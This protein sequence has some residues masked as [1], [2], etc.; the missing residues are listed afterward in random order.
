MGKLRHSAM[1]QVRLALEADPTL[2]IRYPNATYMFE[3]EGGQGQIIFPYLYHTGSA[4]HVTPENYLYKKV[5]TDRFGNNKAALVH[6]LLLQ[7][8]ARDML[9]AE[10]VGLYDKDLN[11]IADPQAEPGTFAMRCYLFFE[12]EK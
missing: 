6:S 10:H 5:W 9:G 11:E 12:F 4:Q 7:F 3:G 1:E 2:G 8:L